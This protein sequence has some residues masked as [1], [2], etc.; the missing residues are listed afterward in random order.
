MYLLKSVTVP[1]VTQAGV[2][3][4]YDWYMHFRYNINPWYLDDWYGYTMVDHAGIS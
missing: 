1:A 3:R 2:N 4:G